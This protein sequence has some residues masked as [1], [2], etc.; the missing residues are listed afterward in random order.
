MTDL[1]FHLISEGTLTELNIAAFR[2]YGVA[3]ILLIASYPL[4]FLFEKIF[5][6]VSLSR[7]RELADTG[8]KALR[9]LSEKAPGTMQ[10]SL[11]VANLAET[12]ARTIGADALLCR[13]GS[14]YHDIGK[15]NNPQYFSENQTATFNPHSL[16]NPRES[17]RIVIQHVEDGKTLAKKYGLPS[18]V[19]DFIET[20]HG[21]TRTEAFYNSWCNEG[22]D[23]AN[24]EDFTYEG[25]LPA[26]PEQVIVMMADAVEAACRSLKDYTP[27]SI[28]SMVNKMVDQR[29]SDSQLQNADISY[30]N[31]R[32][33]RDTLKIQIQ[34]MYHSR[35]TYPKRKRL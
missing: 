14:L 16:L 3:S 17:A 5:G 1:S 12:A 19:S 23:P 11:Q 2:N 4:V 18:L 35:I 22:G 6:F 31:L 8:N 27:E 34:E 9:E 33:I 20:H 30:R 28:S 32:R 10:H 24:I 29:V 15:I 21:K 13:V 26:T 7:L 25:Q